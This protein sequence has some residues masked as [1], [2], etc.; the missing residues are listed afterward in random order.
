MTQATSKGVGDG[1]HRGATEGEHQE[2]QHSRQ[3]PK[4][5]EGMKYITPKMMELARRTNDADVE[6]Y[7]FVTAKFCGRLRDTGLL[8]K[9]IVQDE[10][11]RRNQLEERCVRATSCTSR[12]EAKREEIGYVIPAI[13]NSST[14]VAGLSPPPPLPP[15][16]CTVHT[17]TV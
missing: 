14:I 10:L 13:H 8:E 15:P 7:E 5:E 1:E 11:S 6:L 17:G 3:N 2:P 4:K 12:W 9:P 16:S